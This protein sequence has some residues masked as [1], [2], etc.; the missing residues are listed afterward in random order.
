M[1]PFSFVHIPN[2]DVIFVIEYTTNVPPLVFFP[3]HLMSIAGKKMHLCES[4]YVGEHATL[5]EE[6]VHVYLFLI[7]FLVF[8]FPPHQG[9]KFSL[10]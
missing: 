5:T 6:S 2:R 9:L 3:R 8:R 1:C 10:W 4:T 7:T